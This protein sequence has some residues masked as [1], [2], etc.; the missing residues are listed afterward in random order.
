MRFDFVF[1]PYLFCSSI[2]PPPEKAFELPHEWV[3][4]SSEVKDGSKTNPKV[5]Y[6]K[7]FLIL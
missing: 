1:I 3:A 6:T 4:Y 7:D 2:T 5:G